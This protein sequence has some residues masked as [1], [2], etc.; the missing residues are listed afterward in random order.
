[1][2]F[3][4][5]FQWWYVVGR[6]RLFY[7]E[8]SFVQ[9]IFLYSCDFKA[10]W[11]CWQSAGWLDRWAGR[12]AGRQAGGQASPGRLGPAIGKRK[13]TERRT[14]NR[15]IADIFR[16]LQVRNMML[17]TVY[18]RTVNS[19]LSAFLNWFEL[20]YESYGRATSTVHAISAQTRQEGIECTKAKEQL[21][22][23]CPNIYTVMLA[24]L[25]KMFP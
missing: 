3:T 13:I 9:Q 16:H 1:M 10:A 7:I 15:Q 25:E 2:V 19:Q 17:D 12:P 5:F 14:R 8:E 11:L 23:Y 24:E 6:R 4:R 20:V 22:P 21:R 18:I